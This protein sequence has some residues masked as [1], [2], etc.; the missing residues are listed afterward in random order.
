MTQ[1]IGVIGLGAMGLGMANSLRRAGY[2]VYACDVRVGV[3]PQRAVVRTVRLALGG[4]CGLRRRLGLLWYHQRA[5]PGVGRQHAVEANQVQPR[6]WHQRG[7][8]LHELQR[9][10]DQMRG[11]VAPGCLEL[12]HHLPGGVGLHAFVGQCRAGDVAAQLFQRLAV[13]GRAAHR[14]VQAEPIVVGAQRVE[15]A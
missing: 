10:H 6:P 14:S 11:A 13:F 15:V 8:A 5:Q 3:Q 9:R 7:Q 4:Q 12:E 1:D 2:R